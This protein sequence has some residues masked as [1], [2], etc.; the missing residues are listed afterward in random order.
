MSLAGK[1]G[2]K[3]VRTE[4]LPFFT[5]EVVIVVSSLILVATLL[6]HAAFNAA[7]TGSETQTTAKFFE[8]PTI[9]WAEHPTVSSHKIRV[10]RRGSFSFLSTAACTPDQFHT[11]PGCECRLNCS[12]LRIA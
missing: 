8:S 11:R 12:L 2:L 5:A 6:L 7:A 3:T 10:G 4:K 9:L 1:S